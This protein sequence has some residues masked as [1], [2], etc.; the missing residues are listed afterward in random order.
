[1]KANNNFVNDLN[2]I[3][4]N[5]LFK[6]ALNKAY[7]INNAF[8]KNEDEGKELLNNINTYCK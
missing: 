1:M 5:R 2:L 3:K 6:N 4:K 7:E 8:N